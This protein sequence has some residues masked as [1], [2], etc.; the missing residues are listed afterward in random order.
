MPTHIMN[1]CRFLKIAFAIAI[2]LPLTLSLIVWITTDFSGTQPLTNQLGFNF[3]YHFSTG[4][5]IKGEITPF[6][7]TV[8]FLA[9]FTT[10]VLQTSIFWILMNIFKLYEAGNVFTSV[11]IKYYRLLSFSFLGIA[12]I[13]PIEGALLSLILTSHNPIGEKL[14]SVSASTSELYDIVAALVIMVIAWVMYEGQKLDED[15]QLTI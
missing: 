8:G 10:L 14:L 11:N 6:L 4:L 1:L 13:T 15:K 3:L 5:P 2:V 12:V 7:R 9:T